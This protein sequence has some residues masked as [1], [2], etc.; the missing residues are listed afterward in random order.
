M[1]KITLTE[2]LNNLSYKVIYNKYKSIALNQFEWTGLPPSIPEE[3]IEK[4]L[5]DYGRC[6]FFYDDTKGLMVT[7]CFNG[8]GLN[9][10]GYPLTYKATAFG[11]DKE[12]PADE[13]V[14]ICNNK[15]RIP[16]EDM[17]VHYSA[18]LY[19]I[20]RTL[21]T[22]V[23]A[24]KAPFLIV[25]DDKQVLTMKTIFEK[26]DENEPVIYLDKNITAGKDI[27]EVITCLQTG[28][29]PFLVEL[30]D[31]RHDVENEVL[32]ALG[33]NNANTDKRERLVSD[34]VNANNQFIDANVEL[35]LEARRRACKA[36]N[37]KFGTNIS[38]KLR[39]EPEEVSEDVVDAKT[40]SSED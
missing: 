21:D 29:K 23:K 35:M 39:N 1:S 27:N 22:N 28:V 2:L 33:I 31:Y 6:L 26:L 7:Q 38:V 36:I 11:Y 18:K 10:Q 25:T 34:E 16:T 37:K 5:Y 40:P 3:W 12:Y 4:L 15:L 13:V 20:E 14:E 17:I 19:N 9:Y 30:T 32:S 24:L 8:K